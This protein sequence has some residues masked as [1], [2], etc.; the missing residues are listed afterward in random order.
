[1]T[2]AAS[3]DRLPHTRKVSRLPPLPEQVDPIV[4]QRFADQRAR[5]GEPLNLHLTQAHAP[6][7]TK[8]KSAFVWMLRNETKLGRRLLELTIVRTALI[9]DC[10]Y[11]LDH[12][13]PMARKAGY[14][15]QQIDAL[16]DWRSQAALFQDKELTLLAFIDQLCAG[17][18]VDDPTYA[19]L[20][21]HF[22]PQEIVEICYCATSY[23]A[24]ALFVKALRI[25]IDAPH[26]KAA[27]GKY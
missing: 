6:H 3:A 27:D 8:A 18:E 7:L 25:E 23:Y 5:G 17:G 21:G 14:T 1:M 24:N 16:R 4:A 15:D 11:E 9:V 13:V 26:V 10:A 19:A 20:A 2:N 22:S 12:H